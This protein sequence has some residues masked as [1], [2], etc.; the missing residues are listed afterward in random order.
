MDDILTH[1]RKRKWFVGGTLVTC[2]LCIPLVIG[3]TQ[4]FRGIFA[5]HATGLAAVAGG[6]AEAY[7]TF[8]VVLAFALPITAIFPRTAFNNNKALSFIDRSVSITRTLIPSTNQ[9]TPA[10]LRARQKCS[11]GSWV[12]PTRISAPGWDRLWQRGEPEPDTLQLRQLPEQ[13]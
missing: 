8:A 10:E 11:S 12:P 1:E 7:V 6:L 4:S 3:I 2:V 9:S 13:Q 5:E